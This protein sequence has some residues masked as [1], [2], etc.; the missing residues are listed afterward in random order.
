MSLKRRTFYVC[1]S[2]DKVD[3]ILCPIAFEEFN[4]RGWYD[5]AFRLG[6]ETHQSDKNHPCG[7]ACHEM[8]IDS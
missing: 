2:E 4:F 7:L 6:Q 8:P 3:S 1:M 5:A